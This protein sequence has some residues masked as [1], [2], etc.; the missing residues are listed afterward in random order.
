MKTRIPCCE[1]LPASWASALVNGDTSGLFTST[2]S[3][4][5]FDQW[6]QENPALGLAVSCSEEPEIRWF[7][8]LRT[9]CLQYT[10]M[11]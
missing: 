3:R 5:E 10:W 1:Y 7:N 11:V 6:R 9:E 8:G 4:E 2:R